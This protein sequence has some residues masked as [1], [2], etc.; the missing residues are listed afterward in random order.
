MS[1]FN[2][3]AYNLC[4]N[5]SKRAYERSFL[6]AFSVAKWIPKNVM[7]NTSKFSSFLVFSP[8]SVS[9]MSKQL[10]SLWRRVYW[11]ELLVHEKLCNKSMH[12]ILTIHH[13]RPWTISEH[14]TAG[15]LSS[16]NYNANR[17]WAAVEWAQPSCQSPSPISFRDD[18]RYFMFSYLKSTSPS[19]KPLH[20]CTEQK[21][22][23]PFI[24]RVFKLLD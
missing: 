22:D 6:R 5:M 18:W 16:T 24:V 19:S 4:A 12:E 17:T 7:Y 20:V 9:K 10:I 3:A 15:R 23:L 11:D 14:S 8:S 1:L 21:L 13:W 2:C